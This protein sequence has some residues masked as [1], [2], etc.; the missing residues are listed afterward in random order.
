M[1][2]SWAGILAVDDESAAS[3]LA[4]A[5][6][7]ISEAR[8]LELKKKAKGEGTAQGYV[9]SPTP[10]RLPPQAIV[11]DAVRA[12]DRIA[13]T[14]EQ[15]APTAPI[16]PSVELATTSQKPPDEPLLEHREPK[17]RRAA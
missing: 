14:S 17:R 16:P 8:Y 4:E 6:L 7:E 1:G 13:F 11:L 12:E 5:G 3:I 9:P 15:P 2:G 10:P